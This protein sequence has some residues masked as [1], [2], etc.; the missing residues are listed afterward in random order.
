[1]GQDPR[2]RKGP[3]TGSFH[4]KDPNLDDNMTP[5]PAILPDGS[6]FIQWDP[7]LGE[8]KATMLKTYMAEL[9]KFN[10]K[11]NLVSTSSLAKADSVHFMDCVLAWKLVAPRLPKGSMVYDL[12]AGNGLPGLV[13]AILS[14]EIKVNLVDRDQRKLEFCKHVGATLGL[15]NVVFSC[16]DVD[17]IPDESVH[18]AISRGFAPV[19]KGLLLTR[20]AMAKDGLFFMMKGEGWAREV[21]EIPTQIFGFWRVEMIGQYRVPDSRADYVIIEAKRG[22]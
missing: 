3:T 5:T 8:E 6:K 19:S 16:V 1:M 12:G 14:P 2:D 17:K 20:K 22:S 10:R 13:L 9:F 11:L 7:S 15:K 18:Y 4:K 21:A